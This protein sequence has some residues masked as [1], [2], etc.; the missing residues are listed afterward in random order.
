MSPLAA[1]GW[2]RG[3]EGKEVSKPKLSRPSSFPPRH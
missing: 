1:L 3:R 2:E